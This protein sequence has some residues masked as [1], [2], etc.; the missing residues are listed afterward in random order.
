MRFDDQRPFRFLV[1]DRDTNFS[2]AFD[3]LFRPGDRRDPHTCPGAE[4][5]PA[6]GST[7]KAPGGAQRRAAYVAAD[8]RAVAPCRDER[9]NPRTAGAVMRAAPPGGAGRTPARWASGRLAVS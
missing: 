5:Q 1:H 3:E 7:T 2:H 4:R 9:G 8:G 6:P